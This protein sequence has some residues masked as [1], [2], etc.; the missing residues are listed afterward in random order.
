M[1]RNGAIEEA[2]EMM[3]RWSINDEQEL[4][5][6]E[7]ENTWYSLLKATAYMKKNNFIKA[8]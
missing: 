1:M 7:M 5:S 8:F 2:D 6:H 3:K 4:T